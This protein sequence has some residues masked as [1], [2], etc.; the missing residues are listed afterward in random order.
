M[1]CTRAVYTRLHGEPELPTTSTESTEPSTVGGALLG[2]VIALAAL[3]GIALIVAGI[4]FGGIWRVAGAAA[5]VVGIAAI[6]VPAMA[7]G[8]QDNGKGE[9]NE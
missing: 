6:V 9:T 8:K 5:T 1:T 3:A 4:A 2:L 7:K